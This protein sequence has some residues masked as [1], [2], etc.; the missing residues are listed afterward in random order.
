MALPRA[1]VD[2]AGSVNT[3]GLFHSK[4]ETTAKNLKAR[5]DAGE[6]VRDYFDVG[7]LTRWGGARRRAGRKPGERKPYVTRLSPG[8]IKALKERVG[9]RN[10]PNAKCSNP[11]WLP[12]TNSRIVFGMLR[13]RQG[14]GSWWQSR[15]L[16]SAVRKSKLRP[17]RK[18]PPI[19]VRAGIRSPHSHRGGNTT[20][21]GRNG[22]IRLYSMPRRCG[23]TGTPP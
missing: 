20:Q 2:R 4:S 5:F 22:N 11:C 9:A 18:Q 21:E 14:D 17:G 3:P 13:P 1:G 16:S 7:S 6:S 12:R 19:R 10:A 15:L 8:I 23:E